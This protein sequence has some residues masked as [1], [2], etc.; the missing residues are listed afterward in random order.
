MFL[1][2]RALQDKTDKVGFTQF[3]LLQLYEFYKS[4]TYSG[5]D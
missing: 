3:G 5:K 4:S 1:L 2:D